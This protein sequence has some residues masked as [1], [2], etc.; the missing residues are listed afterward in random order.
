MDRFERIGIPVDCKTE[1]Y[2]VASASLKLKMW[3]SAIEKYYPDAE[4]GDE[5]G[6]SKIGDGGGEGSAVG[7]DGEFAESSIDALCLQKREELRK[8]RKAAERKRRLKG[9]DSG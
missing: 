5:D 8:Y 1:D 6:E 4:R 9:A 7:A 3:F 2:D